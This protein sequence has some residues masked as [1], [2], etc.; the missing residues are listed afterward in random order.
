MNSAHIRL[1][2]VQDANAIAGIYNHYISHTTITFEEEPVSADIMAGRIRDVLALS[3]PW[4]VIEEAGC[5][6]GYAYAS[7]WKPR[8]A[9][10]FSVETSVYLKHDCTGRSL[11][12]QLYKRLFEELAQR[13]VHAVIGGV[14]LP[15]PASKALHESFGMKQIAH[16]EE[17]GFKFGQ[18]LDVG[19]WELLLPGAARPE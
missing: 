14:A 7:R 2:T 4:L 11:G 6:S 18:W 15:N 9:Y 12:K 5:I 3:L 16:F 13:G 8:S 10:R 19:Y 1:A 17:V